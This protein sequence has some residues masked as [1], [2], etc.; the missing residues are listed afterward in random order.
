MAM[1]KCPECGQE[2]S[3]KAQKCIHCG[4]V[5]V[6]EEEK[7][8]EVIRCEEC[9]TILSETDSICP[10]CGCPVETKTENSAAATQPV[11]VAG[12]KMAQKTKKLIIGVVILLLVCVVGGVGFKVYSDKKAEKEYR[13][14]YNL[15]ID[16]LDKAQMLMLSG[17]SDAET[18][19]NLILNVWGNSIYEESDSETDKYT[20]PNGIFVDDFN[21]ALQNLFADSQTNSTISS[22]E[23]NQTAVKEL[24]KKLQNPPEEL[25]KCYDTISD[26]YE[27]Y[28][29]LTELAVNPSGNYSGYSSNKNDAVSDFMVAYDKLDSQIPDK[30]TGK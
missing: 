24:M 26:L 7:E 12:I 8:A 27:A 1:I 25:D 23:D 21:V 6:E 9:G 13:E 15:Y 4:K 28:K 30:K 18:L 10:N 11:E 19:C 5:F 20:R 29:L 17:G 3:D 2:I 16:N 14:A 22:I